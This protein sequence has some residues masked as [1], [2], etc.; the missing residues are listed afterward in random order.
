MM[1][2]WIVISTLTFLVTNSYL[3]NFNSFSPTESEQL[4]SATEGNESSNRTVIPFGRFYQHQET[5][6][7]GSKMGKVIKSKQ[8][9]EGEQV[10]G[11]SKM[12]YNFKTEKGIIYDAA[13][14]QEGMQVRGKVAKYISAA[15]STTNLGR[16]IVRFSMDDDFI[17][18]FGMMVQVNL[19]KLFIPIQIP[20]QNRRIALLF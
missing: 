18:Q 19:D 11:S 14:E 1:K 17:Q 13:S 8:I 5:V 16:I 15:D 9:K 6:P 12:K 20:F 7:F 2:A 4:I 3:P 10:F